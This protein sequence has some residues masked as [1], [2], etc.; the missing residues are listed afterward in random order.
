MRDFVKYIFN[1]I[2][3]AFIVVMLFFLYPSSVYSQK[4][5]IDTT[6]IEK[7]DIIEKI[8]SIAETK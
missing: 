6:N 7:D 3:F 4:K 1:L 5:D 8:E 2:R